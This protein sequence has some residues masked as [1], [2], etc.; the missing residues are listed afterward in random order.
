MFMNNEK[1][2]Q[3]LV[4]KIIDDLA[5]LNE[6]KLYAD[7]EEKLRELLAQRQKNGFVLYT[8]LHEILGAPYHML[9]ETEKAKLITVNETVLLNNLDELETFMIRALDEKDGM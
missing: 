2:I 9:I 3:E 8:Q 1:A 5:A 4:K 7:S 6:N